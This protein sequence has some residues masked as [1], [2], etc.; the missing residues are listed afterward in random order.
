MAGRGVDIR[1]D[2]DAAA[3]GGLHVV[4]TN[5]HESRR[6]DHQLRGRAGRQGDAGSSR[7]FVS[8]EDALMVKYGADCPGLRV[9]PDTIQ[10]IAEGENLDIRLMLIRYETVLEGQRLAVVER[11]QRILTGDVPCNSDVTATAIRLV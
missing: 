1:L 8:S 11:R 4:G 5:R 3:L 6:I 10:R 7:F 2:P 9:L